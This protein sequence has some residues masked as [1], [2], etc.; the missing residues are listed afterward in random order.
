MALDIDDMLRSRWD[1]L[2][3][4]ARDMEED[5]DGSGDN[6]GKDMW[7]ETPPIHPN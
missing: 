2:N 7:D 1:Q 3:Q 6:T 5:K 4:R